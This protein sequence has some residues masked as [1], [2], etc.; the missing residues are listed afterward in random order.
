MVWSSEYKGTD[1]FRG[2]READLRLCFRLGRLL[3][4]PWGGYYL[5]DYPHFTVEKEGDS[6]KVSDLRRGRVM[7]FTCTL[8][9]TAKNNCAVTLQLICAFVFAYAKAAAFS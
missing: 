1:Q 5:H 3:V 2:Y 4:L 9:L 8:P 6:L 7:Y